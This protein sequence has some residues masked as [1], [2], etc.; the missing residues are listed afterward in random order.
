MATQNQ[1]VTNNWVD[2]KSALSLSDDQKYTFECTGSFPVRVFESA[3]A[4]ENGV[5]GHVLYPNDGAN[6]ISVTPANGV[7]VYVRTPQK[8]QESNL[9]V[10]EA[11]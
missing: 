10:T 5:Y 7:N 6:K 4:P 9:T 8:S 11:V 3:S 2:V 1:T